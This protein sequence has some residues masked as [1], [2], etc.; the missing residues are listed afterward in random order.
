[1]RSQT[2]NYASSNYQRQSFKEIRNKLIF[3]NSF[4]GNDTVSISDIPCRQGAVS[5]VAC[6][7]VGLLVLVLDSGIN[8]VCKMS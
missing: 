5:D 6:F 3:I 8:K 7:F 1:M 4:T 2:T